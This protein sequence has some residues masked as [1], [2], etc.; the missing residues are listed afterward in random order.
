MLAKT[1][2]NDFE[3]DSKKLLAVNLLD[4]RPSTILRKGSRSQ[5]TIN[6]RKMVKTE[7]PPEKMLL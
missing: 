7:K 4:K 2:L 6:S 5:G 1:K 3:C